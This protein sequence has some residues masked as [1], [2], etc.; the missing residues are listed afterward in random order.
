MR[1]AFN[2]RSALRRWGAA[3]FSAGRDGECARGSSGALQVVRRGMPN[4]P[5]VTLPTAPAQAPIG[6]SRPGSLKAAVLDSKSGGVVQVDLAPPGWWVSRLYLLSALADRFADDQQ[7]LFRDEKRGFLGLTSA[8]VARQCLSSLH[9]AL[10]DFDRSLGTTEVPPNLDSAVAIVL[11]ASEQLLIQRGGELAIGGNVRRQD[12]RRRLADRM[13]TRH[14][15]VTD[16]DPPTRRCGDCSSGPPASCRS[17]IT[18][19]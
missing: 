8:K 18:A 7:L 1:S 3:G 13:Q 16:T 10:S 9:P 14:V 19:T 6:D 11:Q 4:T 2:L 15:V 5:L 17:I 12:V